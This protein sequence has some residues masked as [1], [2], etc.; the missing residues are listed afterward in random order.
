MKWLGLLLA[1]LVAS[2]SAQETETPPVFSRDIELVKVDVVVVDK[3][4]NPLT[5]LK[6]EDFTLLDQGQPQTINSFEV[7]NLPEN[8]EVGGPSEPRPRV[9]SNIGP[10]TPAARSFVVVFDNLHMTPLGAQRAKA[11]VASF[12]DKGLR[13]GDRLTLAAT[14]GGAWWSTQ[15]PAGRS[16]LIALLKALDGRRT[17]DASRDRIL[18][19]EAMRIYLYNDTQVASRVARRIDTF[20]GKTR[21]D[22]SAEQQR[23]QDQNA[24]QTSIDPYIS[25]RAAETYLKA[26]SRSRLSLA[27]IERV[28]KAL[29]PGTDRKA[30]ILVSEGFVLDPTEDAFKAVTEAARRSNAAMYFVDTRGLESVSTLYS[31]EFGDPIATQDNM[32]A[33]ADVSQESEGSELLASETGGFSVKNTN[34]LAGGIGRI[35]RESRS[36]YLLSFAPASLLRDGRYHKIEVKVASRSLASRGAVIR[37]RRG[38]Y[39]PGE[40]REAPESKPSRTDAEMQQAVDSPFFMEAIPLRMTAFALEEQTLGRARTLFAIEADVSKIDFQEKEG[41]LAGAMDSLLVVAHRDSEETLRNDT[42]LDIQ[43]KPGALHGGPVLYSF[44]REFALA[45]GGYQA[46]MVLRDVASRRI[47]TVAYEF[48]VAPLT[49]LRVST[50]I[51]TD[52]VQSSGGAVAAVIVTHRNF[53]RTGSLYCRFDVYG[54]A[55]PKGG[56]MPRVTVAHVLRRADGTVVSKGDPSE[57]VPTSLGALSRMMEIPLADLKPGAYELVLTVEDQEASKSRELVEPFTVE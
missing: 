20:G 45:P 32:S 9:A 3:A 57:I 48:E 34:D 50:P 5:G 18:D 51:L 43:L 16:D 31:A 14:G 7:V 55:K 8:P 37:A 42:R 23:Q 10:K 6:K 19:Y 22:A 4:G 46:K 39:A 25:M 17:L 24:F 49:D 53:K 12:L 11:A 21:A 30:V 44:I 15:M 35:T 47:G 56:H 13:K 52:T 33:I 40:A 36:Y 41:Q 38:Y 29:A 28:L 26:R 27:A 54:A 1:A 2:A